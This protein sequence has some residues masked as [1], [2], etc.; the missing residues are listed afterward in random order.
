M[1]KEPNS[2]DETERRY[3]APALEKGLDVLELLARTGEPL[4]T[5]QIAAKLE[6]SVSELFRMVLTLES[7]GY[8]AL[9]GGKEGYG[10]TNKMFALGIAQ[11]P[12]RTLI[13]NAMPVMKELAEDIGQSCH[14]VVASNDQIVVVARIESPR[15]MGF[16]VR[17]GYRRPLV[18]STSGIILTAAQSP[19]A[20]DALLNQLAISAPADAMENFRQKVASASEL[21]FVRSPSDFVNG[22]IDLSSPV[23]GKIGAVASLTVPYVNC[24]PVICTEEEALAKLRE[25]TARITEIQRTEGF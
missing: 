1:A 13:E 17:I 18:Y 15:D 25:A 7:R 23:M 22:V 4:T 2:K 3:K 20:R 21:G 6:R 24:D 16:S 11:T 9:V 5:S 10:L 8:I 14:L 19:A 12:T